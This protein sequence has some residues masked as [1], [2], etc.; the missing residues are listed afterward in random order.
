MFWEV[1]RY[2]KYGRIYSYY[3]QPHFCFTYPGFHWVSPWPGKGMFYHF[4]GLGVLSLFITF[5][6][7]Y[8]LSAILFFFAF[9][10]VF[11]LDRARYLNHLYL[12]CLFSFLMIFLPAGN[13][14]SIDVLIWPEKRST[15]VPYWTIGIL[16]FQMAVVYI[17]GAI[18]KMN[19][20]WLTGKPLDI[21][22]LSRKSFPLIGHLFDR[23]WMAYF[24]SYVGL[25][26]DLLLVPALCWKPTLA[27]GLIFC[28]LFNLT[29]ARLFRIG[30]FPWLAIATTL[31]FLPNGFFQGV[32]E[33]VSTNSEYV[34][35]PTILPTLLFVAIYISIQLCVPFRHWFYPGNVSWTEEGHNFSWHMK[36]RNKTATGQLVFTNPKTGEKEGVPV[37][38]FLAP[39][40]VRKMSTR[41][42]MIQQFAI[43]YGTAHKVEVR[44]EI[45][46][47]LNGRPLQFL[48]DPRV[49]LAAESLTVF[50]HDDWIVPLRKEKP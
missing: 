14:L 38:R 32:F 45:L 24:F 47:S 12:V 19:K 40:Q 10:H 18:A 2:Y 46:A 41:P 17:Y 30:I 48:I 49:N 21:W 25:L 35:F 11:L 15:W 3:I 43:L 44:S 34:F 28:V 22:L 50:K 4:F 39:K 27:L 31:L 16:Q 36:L 20:D 1:L 23:K 42:K 29:N 9:T 26:I 5:G 33:R 37:H 6:F 8:Q 7:L 13:A